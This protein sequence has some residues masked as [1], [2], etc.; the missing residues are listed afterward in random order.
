MKKVL[1]V[2][3]QEN[4]RTVV[5]LA[6]RDRFEVSEAKDANSA[7]KSINNSLPDAIILDVMMSGSMSGFQLCEHIKQSDRL[8]GIYVILVTACGQV[9]DQEQGRALGADAYF[10]KPF[11][12]AALEK[13][14]HD[15]L[16]W[17]EA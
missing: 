6:L 8:S 12:P 7:L 13:H 11:S 1:V 3:D 10:V 5:R 9:S 4:I 15:A 16:L 2:D 14:L 17:R